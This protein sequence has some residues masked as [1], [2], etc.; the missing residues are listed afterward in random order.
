MSVMRFQVH[1]N[2][3]ELFYILCFYQ[4]VGHNYTYRRHMPTDIKT[5]NGQN[6]GH[7]DFQLTLLSVIHTGPSF[8]K[9]YV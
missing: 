7:L 1:L 6:L 5:G 4:G 2:K 3:L 8:R 9:L